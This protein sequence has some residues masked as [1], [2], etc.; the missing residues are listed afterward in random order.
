MPTRWWGRRGH[1][2][3]WSRGR[4]SREGLADGRGH[5]R[6]RFGPQATACAREPAWGPGR[7]RAS[8][9]P[10]ECGRT[11]PGPAHPPRP[12]RN[13]G[14]GPGHSVSALAPARGA[15]TEPACR[16]PAGT[17]L[18]GSVTASAC[19]PRAEP[20]CGARSQHHR[21]GPGGTRAW[22]SVTASA[23][24]PPDGTSALAPDGTSAW[25]R[26]GG[27]GAWTLR[28]G[29][30]RWRLPRR[31]R[32]QRGGRCRF[33]TGRPPRGAVRAS[34]RAERGLTSRRFRGPGPSPA[35]PT[36]PCRVRRASPSSRVPSRRGP[37]RRRRGPG[38]RGGAG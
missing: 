21:V 3:S 24:W 14:V 23:R 15:R 8:G 34:D 2:S 37:R 19:R 16:P 5:S 35:T 32:L 12:G 31:A 11:R 27:F 18:W 1:R 17:S 22:G 29:R 20:G 30:R 9:S 6:P 13:P 10:A 4:P 28:E 26:D 25:G 36:R 33:R 7:L 38:R